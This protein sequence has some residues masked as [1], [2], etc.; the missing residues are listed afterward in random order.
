MTVMSLRRTLTVTTAV[1]V[2][3]SVLVSTAVY[4]LRPLQLANAGVEQNR[5]ILD[6]A[7]VIADGDTLSEREIFGVMSRFDTVMANIDTGELVPELD[8]RSYDQR[9]AAADPGTSVAIPAHED[10]A[11]LGARAQ[12]AR[13]YILRSRGAIDRIVLPIHG[14]GMWSTIYGYL[15]LQS[16]LNTICGIAFHEHG[17]TAG[18]GDR[19]LAPEWREQWVGKQLYAASTELRFRI[20]EPQSR[21][22][23][24]HFEV[25]TITGATVTTDAVS[26][27]I[28]Y[29]FGAHG[30]L[31]LLQ[32]L[33][34]AN[35]RG[36]P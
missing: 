16:D 36:G 14:Q 23:Q 13:V 10:L 17:E 11:K 30:F 9:A 33:G 26:E 19:I 18:I 4:F 6:A 3:C 8:A 15:C 25:D 22:D 7:G 12:F 20:V 29:W 24:S 28:G 21:D 5:A 34:T 27:M 35:A 32:T 2:G 1:A 31:P